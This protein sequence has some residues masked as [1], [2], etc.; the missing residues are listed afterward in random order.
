MAFQLFDSCMPHE[1]Y[2]E[3]TNADTY[4]IKLTLKVLVTTVDALRHF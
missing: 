3:H 1:V 2:T 4:L